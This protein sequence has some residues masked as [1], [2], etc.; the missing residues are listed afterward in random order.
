MKRTT[1]RMLVAFAAAA[2]SAVGCASKS[3][4]P[5]A[6]VLMPPLRAVEPEARPVSPPPVREFVEPADPVGPDAA[7][8]HEAAW[9]AENPRPWK[10]IVLHHSATDGGDA[11]SFDVAHRARG[12]DELGYH[13]VVANGDGADDGLVQVG[14]RWVKQKH[15]AHTGGTPE[16]E[17]NELG[18]GICLVGDFSARM[19]SDKQV[20]SL[21]RLVTYLCWVHRIAPERVIGHCDAPDA[22]TS[23]PGHVLRAWIER[24]LRPALRPKLAAAGEVGG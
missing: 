21:T 22:A 2:L 16:N 17:Y 19:P 9:E 12:W 13:F 20:A 14:G 1:T 3:P 4:E 23:C 6:Q 8:E 15:G 11:A 10:Y 5:M 7:P 18:I 24:R